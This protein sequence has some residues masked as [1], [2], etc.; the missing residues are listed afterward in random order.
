MISGGGTAPKNAGNKLVQDMA[1]ELPFDG[2]PKLVRGSSWAKSDRP[3]DE[4][5]R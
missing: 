5:A 3:E 1:D 4:S 2:M